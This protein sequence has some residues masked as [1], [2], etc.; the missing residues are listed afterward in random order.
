MASIEGPRGK[1]EVHGVGC[2]GFGISGMVCRVGRWGQQQVVRSPSGWG[3]SS[4]SGMEKWDQQ[5]QQEQV[6]Q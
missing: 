1:G 6:W 4:L 2:N 3:R 5:Q